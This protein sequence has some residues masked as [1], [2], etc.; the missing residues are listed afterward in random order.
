MQQ[1]Y[2]NEK[3]NEEEKAERIVCQPVTIKPE[4]EPVVT[5]SG[6]LKVVDG[7]NFKVF[8]RFNGQAKD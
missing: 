2:S 5:Y 3:E 1:T 4:K 7:G 6:T 8:K